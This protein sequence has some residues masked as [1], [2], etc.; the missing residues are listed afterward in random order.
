MK[1]HALYNGAAESGAWT[2][3]RALHYGD[4][5]FR[6]ALIVDGHVHDLDRHVQKLAG[7]AELLGLATAGARAAGADAERLAQGC[8]RGVIKLMLWRRAT[9]RGYRPTTSITERLVLRDALAAVDRSA[10]SRGVRV[11]RSPIILSTQPRLAGI[12]HLGR[13]E[14]VL[15]SDAW[16]RGV[17]EAIQCDGAGRPICGTRSN[18]F[19]I[20]RGA[21]YTPQLSECGV[22]GVMRQKVLELAQMLGLRW[23]VGP[24]RWRDFERSDE[25]FLTNSLIGV[26]PVRQCDERKWPTARPVTWALIDRLAHPWSGS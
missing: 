7:D 11:T 15:A 21:L 22:A 2:A 4:G 5:V 9:M 18:L 25:A 10:W 3:S 8:R 26:W 20:T 23:R 17:Q 16:P 6:T 24:F 12:K 19:W 1:T 14:Q 13:M